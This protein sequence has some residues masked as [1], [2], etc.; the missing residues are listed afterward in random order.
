MDNAHR[1][2]KAY[3]KSELVLGNLAIVIWIGLGSFSFWLFYPFAA[4]GFF[5][6]ASFLVFFELGKHGCLSCYYCKTCTIGMGK[7]PELFFAKTGT[8][9]VNKR[10][11]RL[12]PFVYLLLSVVPIVLLAA[13]TVQAATAL[14]IIALLL[15]S[16]FSLYSGAVRRKSLLK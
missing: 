10:A 1:N 11:M 16:S 7:L 14:K 5:S 9:N 6:V 12:F 2:M 15:L 4:I 8:A 3:S 13:S